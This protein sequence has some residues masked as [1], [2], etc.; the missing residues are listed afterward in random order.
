MARF[1][2]NKGLLLEDAESCTPL[3]LC[4]IGGVVCACVQLAVWTD[5]GWGVCPTDSLKRKLY[6][7]MSECLCCD[8]ICS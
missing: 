3:A 1:C 5:M 4:K 2:W 6:F 8:F 7:A